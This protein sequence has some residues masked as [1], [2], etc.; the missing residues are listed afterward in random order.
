M[1]TLYVWTDDR[2]GDLGD[3]FPEV[4]LSPEDW[5]GGSLFDQPEPRDPG[6]NMIEVSPN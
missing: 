1:T 4:L 2:N 5:F 6:W 3:I